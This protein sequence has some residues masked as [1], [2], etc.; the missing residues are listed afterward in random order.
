MEDGAFSLS[1]LFSFSFS[2]SFLSVQ[3]L[4][5]WVLQENLQ[6]R[7][8]SSKSEL[9]EMTQAA[10]EVTTGE[11][12]KEKRHCITSCYGDF[13]FTCYCNFFLFLALLQLSHQWWSFLRFHW[14]CPLWFVLYVLSVRIM[15]VIFFIFFFC[16]HLSLPFPFFNTLSSSLAKYNCYRVKWDELNWEVQLVSKVEMVVSSSLLL[17]LSPL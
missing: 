4:L 7:K 3:S 2:Y 11:L 15:V 16:F 8:E 12:E 17:F 10:T 14:F 6:S 1:L 9:I 13:T 5:R